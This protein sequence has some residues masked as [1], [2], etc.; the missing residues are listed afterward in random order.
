MKFSLA[1]ATGRRNVFV[2]LVFQLPSVHPVTWN[3]I[4]SETTC[5]TCITHKK[6]GEGYKIFLTLPFTVSFRNFSELF[7][8]NHVCPTSSKT[9]SPWPCSFFSVPTHSKWR[10]ARNSQKKTRFY[11]RTS[12]EMFL[13]SPR[14]CSTLILSLS[15]PFLFVRKSLEVIFFRLHVTLSF[16]SWYWV[17]SLLSLFPFRAFLE[18]SSDGSV[19]IWYHVCRYDS[20]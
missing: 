17:V 18:D 7:R 1:N 9:Q 13:L 4:K 2:D 11:S 15:Q 8:I 19:L 5:L 6:R 14:R 10:A 16:S 20:D 3:Q 12:A